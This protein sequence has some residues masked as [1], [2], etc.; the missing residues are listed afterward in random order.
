[1]EAYHRCSEGQEFGVEVAETRI[2]SVSYA[3]DLVLLAPTQQ[4]L[5]KLVEAY[6]EWMR[7]LHLRVTA[8]KTQVWW[9]GPGVRAIRVVDE[10]VKTKPTFRVVGVELAA[11][12]VKAALKHTKTRLPTAAVTTRRLGALKL[13]TGIVALLWRTVVLP[14]GLYGCE[15]IN[16]KAAHLR[17]LPVRGRWLGTG[18]TTLYLCGWR[19]PEVLAGWPLGEVAITDPMGYMR[20][21]QV[22]WAVELATCPG[23]RGQVHRL[24]GTGTSGPWK[25]PSVALRAV[26]QWAGWEM[27]RNVLCE[28]MGEWPKIAAE[29]TTRGSSA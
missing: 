10:G 2:A 22:R 19:A 9:S 28:R 26:L 7:R 24:A 1:M 6:L 25:E 20:Q 4:K 29:Q 8:A 18:R 23:R 21:R 12:E 3:D 11:S 15:V 27:R 17:Q 13:P 5:E 16:V 14:I